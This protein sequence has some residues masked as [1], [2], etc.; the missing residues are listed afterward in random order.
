M[1]GA[2]LMIIMLIRTDKTTARRVEVRAAS[3]YYALASHCTESIMH[4]AW[5]FPCILPDCRCCIIYFK[6]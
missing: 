2:T 1:T 6:R 3:G 5:P 4:A